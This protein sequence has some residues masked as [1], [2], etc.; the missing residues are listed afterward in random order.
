MGGL[1]Q[2]RPVASVAVAPGSRE[3]AQELRGTGLI[4]L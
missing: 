3:R 1:H 2:L 4:A